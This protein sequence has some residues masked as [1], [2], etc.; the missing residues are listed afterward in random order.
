M[1]WRILWYAVGQVEKYTVGECLYVQQARFEDVAC[2]AQT[3]FD[4][5][6]LRTE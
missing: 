3:E 1:K 2:W 4:A 5:L 6:R